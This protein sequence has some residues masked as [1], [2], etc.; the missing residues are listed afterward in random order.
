MIT[1]ALPCLS[2]DAD[3]GRVRDSNGTLSRR[4][5]DDNGTGG[6]SIWTNAPVV[7]CARVPIRAL[8]GQASRSPFPR[9]RLTL[10]ALPRRGGSKMCGVTIRG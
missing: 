9:R 6:L 8:S 4:E 7:L 10:R 5:R 1:L 3:A 2:T